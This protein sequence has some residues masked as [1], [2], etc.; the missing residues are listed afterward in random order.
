MTSK[1]LEFSKYAQQYLVGGV[2]SSFRINPFTGQRM[3]ISRA[4]GPYIYDLDGKEY[5][6][7]FM[8]H[9]AVT[10]GHN[11]PEIKEAIRN[12]IDLGFYAEY[13]NP[14][15]IELAKKIIE[16]VPCAERVRYVTSGTEGTLLSMR[17]ARGY[18]GR[19]K[20]VRIDGHF[21]GGHDYA[22]ANNLVAK[23][24]RDNPGNRLSKMG[25]LTAGVPEVIR[26]TVYL[27]P[28]NQPEVFEKLAREKGHEIA[29]IIM[30]TIDFNNGCIGTTTEYLQAIRDICDRHGIVMI[31]DEVLAGF[32][33][34]ITCG[35]GYYGVTPDLC[36]LGKALTNGVP[37]GAIAGKEKIMMKIMDP[38][39]PVIAGG[40]F[41]GNLMGCAA[42]VT[43]LGIMEKPG[44]FETWFARVRPFMNAI[45]TGFDEAGLPAVVQ[46]IGC[47]FGIYI[48]TR[49]AVR[50]HRDMFKADPILTKKFY[51]KC[52]EKGLYFHTDFTVSEVHDEALLNKAAGLMAEAAKETVKE[53]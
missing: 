34:G 28:W 16:H 30:N 11:R 4:D 44:F 8:G 25:P 36:L 50:T 31:I 41:T 27:I 1:Q 37:L 19:S 29:G 35:Q 47:G 6:D 23:I 40:T 33:T 53:A 7:F 20:I 10:L 45:Q 14:I 32:K 15:V 43:A 51:S 46:N 39:D 21:H 48:G 3:Y 42:G 9:G 17:L 38:I 22:L 13:D 49:D 2:S 12:V 52:I 26:D 24:D 5:I 18:T